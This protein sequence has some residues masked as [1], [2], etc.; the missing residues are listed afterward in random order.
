[1]ALLEAFAG[2]VGIVG[3]LIS[4][5]LLIAAV[6]WTAV[7]LADETERAA[8]WKDLRC[9]ARPRGRAAPPPQGAELIPA[10]ALQGRGDEVS[11]NRVPPRPPRSPR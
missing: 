5:F 8:V 1:V 4:A 7:A 10:A 11:A 2:C 9:R 3:G 6:G